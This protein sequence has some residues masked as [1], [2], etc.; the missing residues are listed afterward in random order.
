MEKQGR[1]CVNRKGKPINRRAGTI[2]EQKIKKDKNGKTFSTG[3]GS[4]RSRNPWHYLKKREREKDR[5]AR[6]Q[7]N[8]VGG[9]RQVN[10]Q[11]GSSEIVF[12]IRVIPVHPS[13]GPELPSIP[14]SDQISLSLCLVLIY[15]V[16]EA[17][18]AAGVSLTLALALWTKGRRALW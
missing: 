6:T 1:A 12:I 3:V 17:V 2:E 5:T 15:C 18:G 13:T 8:R 7:R 9:G 4:S 16:V 14:P 10:R 11:R